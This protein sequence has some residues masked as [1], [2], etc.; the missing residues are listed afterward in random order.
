MR[1]ETFAS[2]FD[3]NSDFNTVSKRIEN[4]GRYLGLGI[5]GDTKSN[6]C[7]VN[8]RSLSLPKPI[9]M[10]H[11]LPPDNIIT[12]KSLDALIEKIV[13][14]FDSPGMI[15]DLRRN[16]GGSEDLAKE[17]GG[18]FV[19]RE[20]AYGKSVYRNGDKPSKFG[21]EFDRTFSPSRRMFFQGEVVCLIG[22][23]TVSSAEGLA[24]MMKA[25]PNCTLIGQPTRGASGNPRPVLLPNGVEIWYS[26]WKSLL[27]DGTCVEG[28]GIEPDIVVEHQ[29]GSDR[30]FEKAIEILKDKTKEK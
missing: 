4:E 12:R 22:P 17:I 20:T 21:P 24:L 15:L 3:A 29:Q 2:K 5:V 14:R 23:G 8:L 30:T 19:D 16:R 1:K 11:P 25:L 10:R 28:I 18:L 6:F 13:S 26:R 27:P 9:L 7:Y